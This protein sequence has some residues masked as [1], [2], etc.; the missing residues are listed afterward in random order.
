MALWLIDPTPPPSRPLRGSTAPTPQVQSGVLFAEVLEEEITK[1]FNTQ[2]Q[3][4]LL[5]PDEPRRI[6]AIVRRSLAAVMQTFYKFM[7]NSLLFLNEEV[8][9]SRKK[10]LKALQQDQIRDVLVQVS[11][12]SKFVHILLRAS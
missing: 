2:I 9:T 3:N 12:N 8:A 11:A 6:D 5:S 4:T 1:L 10:N 7:G